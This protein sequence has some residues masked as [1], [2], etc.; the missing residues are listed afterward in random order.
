MTAIHDEG[1]PMRLEDFIARARGGEKIGLT[2]RLQKQSFAQPVPPLHAT[3]MKSERE[4]YLL[5]GEF[6]F[7][8]AADM[9]PVS[10]VYAYG[11]PGE[12]DHNA[13]VN[14]GIAN[15]RLKVDYERI[16]EAG[17]EFEPKFYETKADLGRLRPSASE[18]KAHAVRRR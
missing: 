2:V 1:K 12:P 4:L 8:A 13:Q 6:L 16:R 14:A 10:K 17:I 9:V 7:R 3:G 18:R 15:E 11:F 5:V